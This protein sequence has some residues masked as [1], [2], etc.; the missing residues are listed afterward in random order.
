MNP[1]K[2]TIN[3]MTSMIQTNQARSSMIEIDILRT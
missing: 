1:I 3:D 2:D